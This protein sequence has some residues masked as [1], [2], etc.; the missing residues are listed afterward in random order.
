MRTLSLPE[1]AACSPGFNAFKG[2][3]SYFGGIQAGATLA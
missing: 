1:T 2:T 3:G